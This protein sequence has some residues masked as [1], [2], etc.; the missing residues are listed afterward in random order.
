MLSS[1]SPSRLGDAPALQLV[2]RGEDSAPWVLSLAPVMV[3]FIG[4]Y[5]RLDGFGG[6]EPLLV[7][8]PAGLPA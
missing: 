4:H 6:E 5:P 2:L 7:F 8:R 3:K 1:P